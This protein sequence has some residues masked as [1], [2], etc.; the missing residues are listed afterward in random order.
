MAESE[1]SLIIVKDNMIELHRRMK[2]LQEIII[3]LESGFEAIN[4]DNCNY[5]ISSFMVVEEQLVSMVRDLSDNIDA[6][7]S[8]I[9]AK[10]INCPY[11]LMNL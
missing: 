2:S 9:K 6:I 8:M 10:G 1:D 7:A 4:D 3:I 5:V 11:S